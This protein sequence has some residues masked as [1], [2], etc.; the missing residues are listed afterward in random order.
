MNCSLIS[1]WPFIATASVATLSVCGGS[2]SS[3]VTTGAAIGGYFQKV[4]VCMGLK[5]N[6][7]CDAGESCN[8]SDNLGKYSLLGGGCRDPSQRTQGGEQPVQRL[9]HESALIQTGEPPE[10]E[11][12]RN[13]RSI[14]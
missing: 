7:A 11:A 4:K 5:Y 12:G 1:H 6:G 10:A 2:F 3:G 13:F 9:R 14:H 8:T